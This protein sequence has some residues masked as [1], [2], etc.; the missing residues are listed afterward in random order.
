MS[1]TIVE[2][3]VLGP[4][5]VIVINAAFF[6]SQVSQLKAHG[7]GPLIT[8]DQFKFLCLPQKYLPA[9]L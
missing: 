3:T 5:V 7:S 6:S 1:S 4:S 2:D 9:P 8:Y